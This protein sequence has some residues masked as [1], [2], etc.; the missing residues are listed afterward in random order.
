MDWEILQKTVKKILEPYN[1]RKCSVYLLHGDLNP[2]QMTG[3]YQNDKIKA[4]VN[5]AHGE[6]FG[7]PMFEAA[8]EGLP[9]VTI[10]WSGQLDFLTHEGKDYFC[11]VK[12]EMGTIQKSAVWPGVL[13][14]TSKWAYADQGSFKMSLR[15]IYKNFDKFKNKATE[16]KKI[17]DEK[18]EDNFLYENFINS[19][20]TEDEK[21]WIK[22]IEKV[23]IYE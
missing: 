23:E 6:G 1:N 2:S 20:I 7:L 9:V 8:R 3:L 15:N 19:I 5:I 16:L 11:K 12:Y 4:M 21:T 10:G 14:E 13:E 18:F 22:E 17:N